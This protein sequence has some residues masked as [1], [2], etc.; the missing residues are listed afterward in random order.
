MLRKLC[1]CLL[2]FGA[3]GLNAQ[4]MPFSVKSSTRYSISSM[5]GKV[6]LDS[7]NFY[8]VRFIQEFKYKKL[9]LGVDMDFLFDDDLH[10]RT[11]DWDKL[12]DLPGK[13]YFFR[14]AKVG[15][16]YFFHYGCFPA[17]SIGN[18]LLM[19]NYSNM[20]FY[21]DLRQN[22]LLLGASPPLPLKPK[23]ELFCSNLARNQVLGFSAHVSPLPDS[24]VKYIDRS[25]MGFTFILDRNQKG[26]LPE[27]LEGGPYEN[28]DLGKDDGLAALSFDLDVPLSRIDRAIVGTYVEAAHIFNNGTG[29]IL[30]GVYADFKVVKVNLEYRMHNKG[31]VPAYFDQHYE[32]ERAVLEFDEF[33]N[34]VVITGEEVLHEHPAT[35]GFYG[36]IQ[37]KIADRLSAMGAWQN[38][39]GKGF[40]KG[41]SL[42]LSMKLETRWGHWENV[43]FSYSKTNVAKL[44]LG[45]FAEPS[46]RLNAS[47]TISLGTNRRWFLICKYSEKY[48][49]KEGGINWWKD[50]RRSASLGAKYLY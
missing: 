7:L 42:W 4:D 30:P 14:Y 47:F 33:T 13:I 39:Y 48:K 17:Y 32:E 38:M 29:F 37:G 20:E 50:T 43:G 34:P 45:K 49:D 27:L 46:A 2:V 16:P 8:Q 22:G 25:R 19:H 35:F 40:E 36:K 5:L 26:N 41:K 18:G 21:P 1:F 15:D 3:L 31:F 44:G 24:T 10:L 28:W 23:L 9:G 6:A 12:S 11:K